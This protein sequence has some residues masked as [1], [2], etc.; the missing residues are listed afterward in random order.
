MS[1]SN[2]LVGNNYGPDRKILEAI[3]ALTQSVEAFEVEKTAIQ[4]ENTEL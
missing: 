1:F 3:T 2:T 4:G